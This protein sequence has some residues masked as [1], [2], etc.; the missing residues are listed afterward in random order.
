M[1]LPPKPFYMTDS[2][3]LKLLTKPI[4]YIFMW[5]SPGSFPLLNF[6]CLYIL[7]SSTECLVQCLQCPVDVM[8]AHARAATP[9]Q[10]CSCW[11]PIFTPLRRGARAMRGQPKARKCRVIWVRCASAVRDAQLPVLPPCRP[12]ET[13]VESVTS[14]MGA[15]GI[16]VGSVGHRKSCPP[17][18]VP[19]ADDHVSSQV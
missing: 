11:S 13:L 6:I 3:N 1:N 15:E 14:L 9:F 7:H 17:P 19:P 5:W 16:M 4:V 8:A 2:I 18:V 10:L 12:Q